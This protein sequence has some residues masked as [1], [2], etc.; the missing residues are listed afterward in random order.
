MNDNQENKIFYRVISL[1]FVVL[2]IIV[3]YLDLNRKYFQQGIKLFTIDSPLVFPFLVFFTLIINFIFELKNEI[4]KILKYFSFSKTSDTI[5][6]STQS[7]IPSKELVDILV[8]TIISLIYVYILPI[9][10][11]IIATSLYMFCIM[12]IENKS[13]RFINKLTKSV[14]ATAITIPLIYYI[15]YGIFEVILP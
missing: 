14:L 13:D 3:I 9:F 7:I 6:H 4:K 1:L 15:F 10:H 5:Q 11:F 8:F 2:V 12:V